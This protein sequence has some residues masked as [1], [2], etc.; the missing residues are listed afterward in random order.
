MA[1]Y[2]VID[3]FGPIIEYI[4]GPK[5]VIANMLNRLNMISSPSNV[6]DIMDCYGL[7]KDDLRS[8]AFL[9]TYQ[10]INHEQIKIKLFLLL[11]RVQSTTHL[12]SF[13][14]VTDPHNYYVIKIGL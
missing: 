7:D 9:I 6:Q 4:K 11:L 10:L 12:K 14:G 3:K 1:A 2:T 13:M 5:N 8:D